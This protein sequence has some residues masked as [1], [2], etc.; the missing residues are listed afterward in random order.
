MEKVELNVACSKGW[1]NLE[2]YF[3]S[4]EKMNKAI[5]IAIEIDDFSDKSDAYQKIVEEFI[6]QEKWNAAVEFLDR[7]STKQNQLEVAKNLGEQ[8]AE[9]YEE[10]EVQLLNN[11]FSSP[12]LRNAFWKGI[13]N[14]I[15]PVFI[16]RK[17]FLHNLKSNNWETATFINLIEIDTVKQILLNQIEPDFKP[18]LISRLNLQWAIDIKNKTNLIQ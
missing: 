16:D 11:E 18:Q 6:N 1:F 10:N 12:T 7:I 15:K 3:Q 13:I 14:Q 4:S 2:N 9:K 8:V 17:M 5:T